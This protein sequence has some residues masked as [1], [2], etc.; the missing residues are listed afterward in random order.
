M[1]SLDA[2]IFIKYLYC[3]QLQAISISQSY[4]VHISD[5]GRYVVLKT[6]L[7]EILKNKNTEKIDSNIAKLS[8]INKVI[9]IIDRN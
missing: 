7:L 8:K 9:N 1:T 4:I 5:P 6:N 2:P 3:Y